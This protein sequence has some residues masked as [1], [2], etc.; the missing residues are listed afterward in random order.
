MILEIGKKEYE[1]KFGLR[2]IRELDK[3]YKVDYQGLKFG[4]GINLAFVGLNQYNPTALV[5]VISCALAHLN[6]P[7]KLNKIERSIEDYADDNDGLDSLFKE[8]TDEMGKSSVVKDSLERFKTE[9]K[10]AE[11]A[12]GD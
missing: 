7:P 6:T 11:E 8:V 2:F 12:Q 1:L 9:T 4:M 3:Q 10:K 5:D